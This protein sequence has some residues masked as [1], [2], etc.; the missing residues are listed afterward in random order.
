MKLII[1]TVCAV[2]ALTL[3]VTVGAFAQGTPQTES[4]TDSQV[5]NT[6]IVNDKPS[7]PST[8][9]TTSTEPTNP[10]GPTS[11]MEPITSVKD[12]ASEI[13]GMNAILEAIPTDKRTKWGEAG[14]LPDLPCAG[15]SYA[16]DFT[17]VPDTPPV[18]EPS[19]KE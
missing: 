4:N 19:P 9:P 8:D 10:A 7:T 1:G 18:T 17:I 13:A 14:R 5:T 12:C 3:V 16:A 6:K 2:L 11:S 15:Y